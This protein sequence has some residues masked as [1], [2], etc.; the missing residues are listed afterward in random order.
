MLFGLFGRSSDTDKEKKI[1]ISSLELATLDAI[2]LEIDKLSQQ[3][4]ELEYNYLSTKTQILQNL[5]KSKQSYVDQIKDIVTAH[6]G[7]LG[8]ES[9]EVWEYVPEESVVV[10][11][12]D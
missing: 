11:R 5:D 3:L 2:N 7:N 4:G 6:G 10:K 1:S 8:S 12:H 9:T